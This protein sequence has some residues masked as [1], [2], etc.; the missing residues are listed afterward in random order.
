MIR[1]RTKPAVTA[2]A[3]HRFK[4]GQKVHLKSWFTTPQRIDEVYLVTAC[5]PASNREFQYRIRAETERHDRV[6]GEDALEPI[7]SGAQV[8]R[9]N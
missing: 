3:I 8:E 6:A 7:G 2:D 5:L 9:T 1:V 4:V